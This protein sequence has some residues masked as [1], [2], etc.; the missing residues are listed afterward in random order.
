[1]FLWDAEGIERPEDTGDGSDGSGAE[2]SEFLRECSEPAAATVGLSPEECAEGGEETIFLIGE[3]PLGISLIKECCGEGDKN[4]IDEFVGIVTCLIEEE[5]AEP[6]GRLSRVGLVRAVCGG[7]AGGI[8][9]SGI[10]SGLNALPDGG[11]HPVERGLFPIGLAPVCRERLLSFEAWSGI[12]QLLQVGLLGE[13]SGL[14]GPFEECGA[15]GFEECGAVPGFGGR[16]KFAKTIEFRNHPLEFVVGF[17]CDEIAKA[18]Q[19]KLDTWGECS[20]EFV[21]GC[22][23]VFGED[24]DEIRFADASALEFGAVA[25]FR[26][27]WFTPIDF[28]DLPQDIEEGGLLQPLQGIE[29]RKGGDG[30]LERQ[31]FRE[32]FNFQLELLFG[33]EH[34]VFRELASECAS[35]HESQRGPRLAAREGSRQ[36][37]GRRLWGG[38]PTRQQALWESCNQDAADQQ[39]GP[40]GLGAEWGRSAATGIDLSTDDQ[41]TAAWAMEGNRPI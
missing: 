12:E 5:I 18:C 24:F 9:M 3:C 16:M 39:R 31:E 28:R 10:R 19:S 34:D 38:V 37:G 30:S 6:C 25:I 14:V 26:E 8:C 2:G 29:K 40:R 4:F 21:G 36:K 32:L 22:T 15:C 41:P 27:P 20:N 7:V 11:P 35:V 33:I 13:L 17:R 1:M 23:G